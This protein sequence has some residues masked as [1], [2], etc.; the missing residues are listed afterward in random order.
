MAQDGRSGQAMLLNLRTLQEAGEHVEKR[1][2]PSLFQADPEAFT[3]IAP[4]T[5]AFDISKQ[6]DR[7]YRLVG[8]VGSTLEMCC[9]RCLEPLALP[10]DAAFDLEYMPRSENVGEGEREIEEDDLTTA[11]YADETIDL[12][13][14]MAEQLHLALPMKPL[15]SE[16]CRGLCPRC[17][18]NQ[19]VASCTCRPTRED[20]RLAGL[21]VLFKGNIGK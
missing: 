8:H 9:S 7:H 3:V 2:Q 11:F 4:V 18:T 14:L 5:L 20:S 19:N 17:G 1:Y 21:K 13:A 10:I 12:G 6:G 15:C 16:T